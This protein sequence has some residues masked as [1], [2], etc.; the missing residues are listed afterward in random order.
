MSSSSTHSRC[1]SSPSSSPQSD[2][3]LRHGNNIKEFQDTLSR[4][5]DTLSQPE[6][7]LPL[8]KDTLTNLADFLP[9]PKDSAMSSSNRSQYRDVH[10]FDASDRNITI[11]GLILTKGVTNANLYTMVEIIIIVTSDF[12]L[13]NESG[14]TIEKDNSPLRPGNYYIDSPRKSLHHRSLMSNLNYK[15]NPSQSTMKYP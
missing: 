1:S 12:D 3:L 6:D 10:I 9:Q 5:N 4:P 15:Q 13:R 2:T 7:A 8:R 11:G 14:V